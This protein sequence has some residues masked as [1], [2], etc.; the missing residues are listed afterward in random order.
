[1]GLPSRGASW[2]C[3]KIAPF[4]NIYIHI[5]LRTFTSF[6]FKPMFL[7]YLIIKCIKRETIKL[8]DESGLLYYPNLLF[9][10]Q[11][12]EGGI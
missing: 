2:H 9:T 7:V 8:H 10:V 3:G 12:A 11:I 6:L 5:Q 4:H 1:M